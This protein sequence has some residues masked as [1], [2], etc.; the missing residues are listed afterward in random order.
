MIRVAFFVEGQTERIFIEKFLE[1]YLSY[2]DIKVKS[3]KPKNRSAYFH[4]REIL[5][6]RLEFFKFLQDEWKN[7][8][9]YKSGKSKASVVHFEHNDIKVYEGKR[10]QRNPSGET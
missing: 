8:I 10:N 3:R 9:Y 1:Q 5:N 6:N 2:Q 7:Y 4:L